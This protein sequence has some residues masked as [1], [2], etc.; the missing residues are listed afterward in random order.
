MGGPNDDNDFIP[1]VEGERHLAHRTQ[2]ALNRNQALKGTGVK[3]K[4]QPISMTEAQYCQIH[5]SAQEQSNEDESRDIAF[6][7]S[8][9]ELSV[10]DE[11]DSPFEADD[12]LELL[13]KLE[14]DKRTAA[15]KEKPKE[16]FQIKDE[17]GL[18][19]LMNMPVHEILGTQ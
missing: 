1:I 6:E 14:R 11:S 7:L 4:R 19:Q 18:E 13:E 3:K 10:G 5:N 15:Q 8:S 12:C 17:G 16:Q 2:E 9:D